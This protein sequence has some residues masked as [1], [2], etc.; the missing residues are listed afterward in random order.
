MARV[1]QTIMQRAFSFMEVREDLLEADDLDLRAASLQSA[2]NMRSLAT[3]A[4]EAR[5]GLFFIRD[6]TGANDNYEIRPKADLKFN[7]QIGDDFL[8]VL[9]QNGFVIKDIQGAPWTA[10]DTIWVEPFRSETIIGG[11]FG[12]YSLI[13]DDGTWTLQPFTFDPAAGGEIAQPYWSFQPNVAIQP[14]ARKG[15]ITIT[16]SEP[17]WVEAY[18]GQR[19]RYNFRE[20]EIT[21]YV[22]T[23]ELRG[24]VVNALPPSYAIQVSKIDQFRVGDAVVGADTGY[25][26]IV[27]EIRASNN[28]VYMTTLSGFS[29]PDVGERVATSNG[30]AEVLGKTEVEPTAPST[31]WDEPLISPVRGYPRSA[32]TAS[33]RLM[34]LDF[35]DAAGVIATS[36]AR[37]PKDFQTGA[38]DDDAIVREYGDNSPR[39]LHAINMGDVVLFADNG[40][41]YVPTRENGVLSPSTF[42]VIF[43]DEIGSS[44]IRPV[45][46]EDGVI[47]V[48]ASRE[49]VSA[50]LLDGNIY[51]KWSVRTMTTFHDHQIRDP[52]KLCGPSLGAG[53]TEK[54]V[55]VINA[56]GTLAAVSWQESIRD[57][58]I[59]FAPWDTAGRFISVAP[60]FGGYWALVD[61]DIEGGTQRMLE[62]FSTDAYLDSAVVYTGASGT[63]YLEVNGENLEVNGEDLEV[64]R[65]AAPHIPG[66]TATGYA[67]GWDLGDDVVASDGTFQ[68][69]GYEGERQ[70]GLNFVAEIKLWPAELTDS[71]RIG[72]ITARVFEAIISIQNTHGFEAILNR[73]TRKIG[74]YRFGD[75]LTEPPPPRTEVRRFTIFGN[76]DHPDI[77]FRKTRPG[78]F[79]VLATGQKVQG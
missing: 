16:A 32:S 19:I 59:G 75:D 62:K 48:D 35:P 23:T 77:T 55:F 36:S 74:A 53:I 38:N 41:Y 9:D 34:L 72:S 37:G 73:T 64:S 39:W 63:D 51:L 40:V 46:V 3:R 43:V 22:S 4:V 56:D 8:Q 57:E 31:A 45:K 11:T 30:T 70:I 65:P 26:G 10:A 28:F 67:G 78:R 58:Q 18:V 54:Y 14:S 71:R 60:L 20:I 17:I 47:F 68:S 49:R 79:R 1:K 2:R 76:R 33:G 27:T 66:M 25:E 6:A 42:N 44:E 61:R 50:A 15:A 69:T 5:P 13:Y 12:M 7:L 21:E 24:T 29:G 52:I